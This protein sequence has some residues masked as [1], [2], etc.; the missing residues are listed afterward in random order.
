[1][2]HF[3]LGREGAFHVTIV[4]GYELMGDAF[5]HTFEHNMLYE[6]QSS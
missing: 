4:V 6:A 3:R 5:I 2:G 1:M